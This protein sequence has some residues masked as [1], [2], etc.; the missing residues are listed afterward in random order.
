ML[1][2]LTYVAG[3]SHQ[4]VTQT[5]QPWARKLSK[6]VPFFDVNSYGLIYG[7]EPNYVS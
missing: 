2:M 6:D 1:R 3:W 7:L 4:Y 5:N